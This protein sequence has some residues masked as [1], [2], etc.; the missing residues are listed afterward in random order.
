MIIELPDSRE[1]RV[2][3]SWSDQQARAFAK[4]FLAGEIDAPAVA[5]AEAE[6]AAERELNPLLL[7]ELRRIRA[8]LSADRVLIRD[9]NGNPFASRLNL[10]K[11]Q[12]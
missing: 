9:S 8:A 5:A 3:D 4:G 7:A 2:P 1:L 11:E 6:R 12:P 10:P